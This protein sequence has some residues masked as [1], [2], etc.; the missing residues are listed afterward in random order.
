MFER[1]TPNIVIA[2]CVA[3]SLLASGLSA[4]NAGDPSLEAPVQAAQAEG[5]QDA[6]TAPPGQIVVDPDRPQWLMRKD[7]GPFFMCGPG[8]PEDFLYRGVLR[9]DGTRQGDQLA[10][11]D[12]LKGTGA[13]SIY[14]MAV[15][16]HGGDGDSTHNPFIDHDPS[17]EI[18]NRILDQWETWFREMD[19]HGIV[20]FFFIYDDS[21]RIWDTGD[22]VNKEERRFLR[23]LVD[24]FEH[25]R[26][27][28]WVV[29]EEYEERYSA[30][31]VSRIAAE[32][33]AADD[34]DHPIAVHKLPGLGFAEFANDP[35][36]DQFAIQYAAP[37]PEGLQAATARMWRQARGRYNLNLAETHP[38]AQG[39]L[40]RLRNWAVAMGG[41]YSMVLGMDIANT[42][43]SDLE[44]CGRL[45]GFME[46]TNFN[47]MAPRDDL[48]YAGTRY[49]LAKP[50]DSYIA[51]APSGSERIGL[52]RMRTGRYD[53]TW[54]DPVTG[55]RIEWSDVDV[56]SGSQSWPKPEEIGEEVAVYVRLSGT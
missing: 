9:P 12:K 3:A 4:V 2:L 16:S 33:R 28:I 21:A 26:H 41:A 13:N 27:L 42:P 43:K 46:A 32:I 29:A 25:H 55:T 50:R 38:T 7:V 11:I 22:R 45:V 5:S 24:R 54:F 1:G 34:F 51:Y 14:L 20:I 30:A 49:V 56:A 53:F 10:L 18:N 19:R 15:R 39:R 44:D 35:N 31:R 52:R 36:I 37:N 40:V 6:G 8:D 23:T 48:A 47:E 17:G